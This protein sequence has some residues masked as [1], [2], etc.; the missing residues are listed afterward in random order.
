MD[1]KGLERALVTVNFWPE[2]FTYGDESDKWHWLVYFRVSKI[3]WVR[4]V[5]TWPSSVLQHSHVRWRSKT[6]LSTSDLQRIHLH[7]YYDYNSWISHH[8]ISTMTTQ[9][10]WFGT[11][12]KLYFNLNHMCETN[13][14][15]SSMDSDLEA[16]SHNLADNSF[17]LLPD[18]TG[19]NTKY[20]ICKPTCLKITSSQ[21]YHLWIIQACLPWWP[22]FL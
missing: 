4:F 2:Y 6:H 10:T 22:F 9:S 16:F 1:L 5:R 19:A 7:P 17:A 11:W 3:P 12:A 15:V 21:W 20:V 18:Q 14:I 8:S 13:I